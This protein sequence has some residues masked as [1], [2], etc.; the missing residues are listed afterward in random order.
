MTHT[1]ETPLSGDFDQDQPGSWIMINERSD[2]DPLDVAMFA[3]MVRNSY[4]ADDADTSDEETNADHQAALD[5]VASGVIMVT[6]VE[7]HF[8]GASRTMLEEIA[9]AWFDHSGTR[10]LLAFCD[11]D[12]E[13]VTFVKAL[14]TND[15]VEALR[16]VRDGMNHA[17]HHVDLDG[18][19]VGT[20]MNVDFAPAN[21]LEL[22]GSA[23][24]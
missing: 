13:T 19:E 17:L 18:I 15:E 4:P 2:I 14:D 8:T 3:S 23:D 5:A 21:A 22:G 12:N 9:A 11:A 10:A 1:H 20:G 24:T 6:T 7:R 16:I